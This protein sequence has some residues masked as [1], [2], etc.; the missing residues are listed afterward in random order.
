[1]KVEVNEKE[2]LVRELKVEVPAEKVNSEI[3]QKL[4][5]FRK[6]A[7]LKGFRKGKVP[8]PMIKSLYGEEARAMVADEL[9]KSTIGSAAREKD[10]R[11]AATPKLTH[12][13]FTEVGDLVYTAEVEVFPEMQDVTYEGLEVQEAK[14]EVSDKDVD[15]IAE[16]YRERFSETRPVTREAKDSDLIVVDMEKKDD[17]KGIMEQDKFEGVEID[18][19]KGQ[20]I[21]E[22]K[23]QLPG[24]KTGEEKDVR[25]EY[26]EDYPEE[27]F[28][29]ASI[30]YHVIVKEVKEK[31]LP[32]FDDALA[33][34]SG[35]AETALELK[36][37]IRKELEQEKMQQEKNKQR[38][39]LIHQLSEKNK[40]P[41]P[42]GLVEEYLDSMVEDYKKQFPD[43]DPADMRKQY[44][45][46]AETSIRWN[47]LFHR[48][49]EQEGLEVSQS[50]VEEWIKGFAQSNNVSA[51]QA[52]EVLARS[53][54]SDSIKE[55]ILEQKVL[56]FLADRAKKVEPK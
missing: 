33:K 16:F 27:R 7:D 31:I 12:L 49:A 35:Q 45:D 24:L 34:R 21:K 47:L 37:K 18:L 13:D 50:D 29:G 54:R 23:E 44:R 32:D 26:A 17:P 19:S 40:L 39:E 8:M 56:D 3:N 53:G 25:V 30:T 5:D 46:N 52:K 42:D 36:M 1:M 20:T 2:G 48:L 41:I 43:A 11:V 38:G 28:A 4:T 22:F 51:E 15:E 9:I 55:S 6:K 10:L 14:P